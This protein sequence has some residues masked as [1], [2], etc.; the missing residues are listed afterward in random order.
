MASI[1]TAAFYNTALATVYYSPFDT[2][3][4]VSG[5]ISA[6][7]YDV[8]GV[9]FVPMPVVTF[10]PTD[11]II[12]EA[13]AARAVMEGAAV[14]ELPVATRDGYWAFDGWFTEP[15]GGEQITAETT[16]TGDVTYY[17][18]WTQ[19]WD[20]ATILIGTADEYTA[21]A[22]GSWSEGWTVDVPATQNVRF[23]RIRAT[24]AK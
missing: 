16:V 11:G 2:E 15:E 23:F 24:S 14:G 20:P 8:S 10:D 13:D 3:E 17:A 9:T 5:L 18:H 7:G 21:A 4:R 6:T 19:T 1:G 22:D 12:A